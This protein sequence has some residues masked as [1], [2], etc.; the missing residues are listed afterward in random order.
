[1][2][3]HIRR[4]VGA[5]ALVSALGLVGT[6]AI[7]AA[8][9]SGS[10]DR[11]AELSAAID[12]AK[13]R[14]VILFI[15]DGMDDSI[16]TA[17]RNYELGADGRFAL[18]ELPFTGAMTTHGYKVGPGPNYPI[19]YVSDSAPTAS[20]W[21]TGRKTVDSR[22][23]Q[24]PSTALE[25]PGQD[26]ETA[27]QTYAKQGKRIG[28]ITTSEITDAT[29]AAAATS[30]N[31]RACQ[32][33][34]DLATCQAAK[35]SNGGKG[36]I[37]EQLVDN[38][39]DVI[40]GGGKRRFDQRT[41]SG[42]TVW[43]YAAAEKDYKRIT[44]R[45]ALRGVSSLD[46]GPV[47]GL[48]GS[49]NL[50]PRYQPLVAQPGGVGGPD[51]RCVASDRGNEPSLAEMT[52][53]SIELLDN[54]KGFFLQAESAMVDKQEHAADICGAVGDVRE[55]DKALEVALDYQKRNPDTLILITADHGHSTQIVGGDTN[56]KQTATI[57]TADGFPLT[58]AFSTQDSGSAHTGTQVRVAA[59]GPQG[60]NVT[61]VIDQTDLFATILGRTPS[62]LA[63]P[64]PVKVE[65]PGKPAVTIA[66]TSSAKRSTIQK[67]GITVTTAAANSTSTTL[68]VTQGGKTLLTRKL[69]AA[70]NSTVIKVPKAAVGTLTLTVKAD[71]KGGSSS[72]KKS[73]R[74]TAG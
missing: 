27:M 30:I 26:Y 37:A 6:A 55:I 66:A 10:K 38:E 2:K 31:N 7:G 46:D 56:G 73:V 29:P 18:D 42:A 34:E 24:G 59:K 44:T 40:L 45:T 3:R 13:P 19:A 11:S 52:K 23:S 4:A 53:K 16:I 63:T 64:P 39:I 54:E 62:T 60:A 22:I 67:K 47:I 48:F 35:K 9:S 36:S 50:T 61:G 32:G 74:I 57:K 72:K 65:V 33:P 1:M 14:N 58:V 21:S 68:T 43:D 70:G 8:G 25:V 28:N 69:P 5:V 51:Q 17:A 49:G 41:E 20:A 71:G 15:G 12:P